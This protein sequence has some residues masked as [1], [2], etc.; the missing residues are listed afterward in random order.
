[1]PNNSA[2]G[3]DS[4]SRQAA[5]PRRA[6]SSARSA[7][8]ADARVSACCTSSGQTSDVS[9]TSPS[10]PARNAYPPTP[11]TPL[12]SVVT[13][14]TP[15]SPMP[16]NAARGASGTPSLVPTSSVA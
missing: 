1:M 9:H 6:R 12:A 4:M 5:S 14:S 7:S 11:S 2:A 3:M 16:R 15:P 8:V 10:R 13:V